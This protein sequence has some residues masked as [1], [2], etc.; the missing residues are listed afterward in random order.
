MTY[1]RIFISS[2]SS[3]TCKL[4]FRPEQEAALHSLY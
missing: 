2:L 1:L 4:R 3:D